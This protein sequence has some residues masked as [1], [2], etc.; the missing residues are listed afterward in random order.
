VDSKGVGDLPGRQTE[1]GAAEPVRSIYGVG[2]G[3][4]KLV[5]AVS[6]SHEH[7]GQRAGHRFRGQ[8]TCSISDATC[9]SEGAVVMAKVT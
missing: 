7:I 4:Q 9:L 5:V 8:T 3:G 2:V 1:V 6:Q